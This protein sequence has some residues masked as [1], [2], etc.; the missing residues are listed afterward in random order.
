MATTGQKRTLGSRMNKVEFFNKADEATENHL[1]FARFIS[2]AE[3]LFDTPS[4]ADAW[5]EA[6]IVNAV[7]LGDWENEGSPTDWSDKW[8]KEFMH[9]ATETI[10][11]LKGAAEAAYEPKAGSN[12]RS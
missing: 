8:K 9:D 1:T 3:H 7:A 6:E 2:E 4:Y 12:R 5:F 10:N 11:V